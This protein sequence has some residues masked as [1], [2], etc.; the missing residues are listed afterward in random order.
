[1][2][3]GE[4]LALYAIALE[5]LD[6]LLR[7]EGC[8]LRAGDRCDLRVSDSRTVSAD[9]DP[10]VT[11]APAM[12]F[13]KGERYWPMD[14]NVFVAKSALMWNNDKGGICT[15]PKAINCG[16]VGTTPCRTKPD[17]I[18]KQGL[19]VPLRLGDGSYYKM[20]C[21]KRRL[22]Q[23]NRTVTGHTR[24]NSTDLTSPSE[25]KRGSGGPPGR[26]GMFLDLDDHY[27]TGTKPTPDAGPP[28]HV[29]FK[30]GRYIIYWFF[31]GH[32]NVVTKKPKVKDRHEGDW[33][34]IVVR[35]DEHNRADAIAYYAHY[36]QNEKYMWTQLRSKKGFLLEGEHPTVWVA[37][38]SH[39]S[40]PDK[41]KD[42]VAGQCFS[43][44]KGVNDKRTAG[45]RWNTWKRGAG[46][47]RRADNQPWY[48]FGGGW[49]D[50]ADSSRG[51]PGP[52]WGP[53]G[54]GPRKLKSSVP[55]R[56]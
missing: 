44:L 6:G 50:I 24:W 39:A 8:D 40:Y 56:W 11:Y 23:G 29:E 30:T 42:L 36:C 9:F 41:G 33:E 20:H 48:G 16:A 14:P 46:G 12:R 13:S 22:L 3:R 15:D 17:V 26:A 47:F 38:G 32:N 4:R 53:L 54:P 10:V 51:F 18:R 25:K 19:V 45:A 28:M 21:W 7:I 43:P 55:E 34:H 1:V 5:P 49:G 35:L 31:Y 27:A 37:K 52:F 2:E